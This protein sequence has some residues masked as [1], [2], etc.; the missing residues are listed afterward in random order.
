M[1]LNF[2]IDKNKFS[3]ADSLTEMNFMKESDDIVVEYNSAQFGDK[4]WILKLQPESIIELCKWLL[5]K[6]IL[7]PEASGVRCLNR[8][9][10]RNT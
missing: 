3:E 10:Y 6:G 8:S 5:M 7:H 4:R 2:S 9:Y 1:F